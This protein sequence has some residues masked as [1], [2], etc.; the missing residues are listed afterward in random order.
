MDCLVLF[1]RECVCVCVCLIMDA[2]DG[3]TVRIPR[4]GAQSPSELLFFN[5]QHSDDVLKIPV[6][7]FYTHR[8][9]RDSRWIESVCT[10]TSSRETSSVTSCVW[11]EGERESWW[12]ETLDRWTD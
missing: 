9:T 2:A 8:D 3:S 5:G 1:V 12:T 4:L 11:W 7:R 6:T 10:H